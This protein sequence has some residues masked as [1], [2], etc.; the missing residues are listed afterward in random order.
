[1][2]KSQVIALVILFICV[3][4]LIWAGVS[5]DE[6][7]KGGTLSVGTPG[8]TS[9]ITTPGP[10]GSAVGDP[11]TPAPPTEVPTATPV[12]FPAVDKEAAAGISNETAFWS[13][14]FITEVGP[15][16]ENI[17]KGY[18]NKDV[19]G[20]FVDGYD[21]VF[22][23]EPENGE[24]RIY[25]TFNDYMW[26]D[27]NSMVKILDI[28]KAKNVKASFFLSV[29][30]LNGNPDI[31]KRIYDEGHLIGIYGRYN[32][33]GHGWDDMCALSVDDFISE[34]MKMEAKYREI[35]GDTER[36][37]YYRPYELSPQ[38][39]AVINQLG[40]TAA[41]HTRS[42]VEWELSGEA[43]PF[44]KMQLEMFSG[45]IMQFTAS[46]TVEANLDAYITQL[47]DQNF[48]VLRLDQ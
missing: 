10:S 9:Y 16:G 12:V 6:E 1:M 22:V 21:F 13:A 2:R 4:I 36:M 11:E 23:K 8:T 39:L 41:L 46:K 45:C 30:Y 5:R 47:L 31:V 38:K 17:A 15:N 19:L 43:D 44:A 20:P 18:Y 29:R 34:L 35:V 48:Q 3:T 24:N 40:Y 37:F 28:L 26:D 14:H 32:Q 25:L 42:L 27:N 7:K 33:E